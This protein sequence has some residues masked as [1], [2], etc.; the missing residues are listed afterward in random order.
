MPREQMLERLGTGRLADLGGRLRGGVGGRLCGGGRGIASIPRPPPN[1]AGNAGGLHQAVVHPERGHRTVVQRLALGDLVLVVRK[2]EVETAAVDVE[3][4]PEDRLAHR[5][6]L[7]VPAGTAGAPGALPRWFTRLGL[8]PEGEVG[9]RPLPF[10]RGTPFAL[11]RLD[12]AI[13]ELAVVGISGDVEVGVAVAGVGR[14]LGDQ[15]L[16]EGDDRADV[17]GGLWHHVDARDAECG[18]VVEVVGGHLLGEFR[19]RRAADGTLGDD[20][21]VD[22]GD[23]DDPGHL[24]AGV[25]EISLHGVEDHRAD[26]VP[27][28][29]RLVDRGAAEI[30]PHVAR[31]HRDQWR[32]GP[33]QGAVD[34]DRR[35]SVHRVRRFRCRHLVSAPVCC[36][37]RTA[38]RSARRTPPRPRV[39]RRSGRRPRPSSP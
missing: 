18:E 37:S 16:D 7:D 21:V 14:P 2:D 32:L 31:F 4:R 6:A 5:R 30:H 1:L 13:G 22:V 34:L 26:H 33:R 3:V 20:L 35:E 12:R 15:S 9:R 36:G 29:A 39:P 10:R 38:A 11:H 17:L 24:P 23:I 19:H 25:D 8:L 28:V 27:D